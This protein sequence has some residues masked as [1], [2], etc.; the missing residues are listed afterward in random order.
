MSRC[1]ACNA[2]IKWVKTTNGKRM[3][4]DVDPVATNVMI[5]F[6]GT[7]SLVKEAFVSHFATC[8]EPERFRGKKRNADK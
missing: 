2:K 3:P 1:E 8:S 6:M 4:L 5:E 7:Y